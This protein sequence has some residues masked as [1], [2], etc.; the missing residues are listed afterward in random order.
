M[1][2]PQPS[3]GSFP[4]CHDSSGPFRP[5]CQP[6]NGSDVWVGETYHVTWDA[7]Y[8]P[9]N[10]TITIELDYANA[11]ASEGGP[12]ATSLPKTLNNYGYVTITMNSDWLKG[13]SRNNLT[14][15]IIQLDPTPDHR[16]SVLKGPTISLINKPVT[17]Y[18]PPPP[19][20]MPNKLGLLV[21][22]PISLGFVMFVLFGLFLGMRKHRKIGLGSV[23][24]SRKGYGVGKSRRQRV[25]KN[26]AIRLG[27]REVGVRAPVETGFRDEPTRGV[28][29][30]QRQHAREE[31]LD[32]L[33]S[34]PTREHFGDDPRMQ[35]NA[36]R[37]EIT[38]QKTGR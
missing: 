28:E 25:G 8:Y 12:V 2:A 36:F 7:D 33:V 34:S 16:T 10:S 26:G 24:G 19:T 21:G 1:S 27:E 32:D 31:N 14:L 29:L 20:S 17:H 37:D 6:T 30:Q 15:F 22:L 9:I 38:R 3:G 18:P 13:L 11:N 35:G 5:F 4:V 23:M